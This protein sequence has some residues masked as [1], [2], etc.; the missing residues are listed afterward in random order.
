MFDASLFG[1]LELFITS[2]LL[3]LFSRDTVGRVLTLPGFVFTQAFGLCRTKFFVF[4]L[5]QV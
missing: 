2:L 3:C 4:S 5:T 1:L